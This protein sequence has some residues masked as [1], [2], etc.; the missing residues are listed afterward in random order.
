MEVS[1][2]SQVVENTGEILCDVSMGVGK[3]L[4]IF[5]G[6]I[7]AVD[8]ATKESFS[9]K[10]VANSKLSRS[11]NEKVFP[12]PEMQDIVD[13]SEA[14]TEGTLGLGFKTIIR[15]GKPVYTIKSFSGNTLD[16]KLRKYNNQ[17]IRVLIIDD[18]NR[19]WGVK[20]GTNYKGFK[21]KL[22]F[23][24]QGMATGQN[25]EVGVS[26]Y[27]LS[28]LENSE[29][30]DNK[31]YKD[32]VDVSSIVGL[33]DVV[34]RENAA[35]VANVF[36]IG[37]YVPT[38]EFGT[39]YNTYDELADDMED[40]GL[41]VAGWGPNYATDIPVTSSVKA[42][43]TKDWTVTLDTDDVAALP[44]DTPI[45]IKWVG[46]EVLDAAGVTNIESVAVVVTK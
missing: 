32:I 37:G 31:V 10:L 12:I 22:F 29:F 28:I 39:D 1:L 26:T 45:Q 33:L 13:S 43:G 2:C 27:T 46:P 17:T 24:G 41:W 4:L 3:K 16:Q 15:E 23:S 9:A 6:T 34:L 5:N 44:A 20:V 14:N 42:A 8:G 38:S 19:C 18:S 30:K 21:A 35:N 36:H 11:D 40:E 25:V 7:S